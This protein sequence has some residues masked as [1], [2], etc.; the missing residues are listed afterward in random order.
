M[1]FLKGAFIRVKNSEGNMKALDSDITAMLVCL[2]IFLWY[3]PFSF[4]RREE[5]CYAAL[6]KMITNDTME[7]APCPSDVY[8]YNT[9]H[10]AVY[11]FDYDTKLCFIRLM[12]PHNE[13]KRRKCKVL[14]N[15][16]TKVA[17]YAKRSMIT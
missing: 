15:V 1:A 6:D 8:V 2:N 16:D 3:E 14:V 10:I 13:E 5:T 4:D 7:L 12:S 11:L 17:F 9:F